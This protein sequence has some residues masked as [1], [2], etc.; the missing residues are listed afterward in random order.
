MKSGSPAGQHR[1]QHHYKGAGALALRLEG[2]KRKAI[3]NLL[4]GGGAARL[5]AKAALGALLD[6]HWPEAVWTS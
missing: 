2:R 4:T 6:A 5:E 1:R 3:L